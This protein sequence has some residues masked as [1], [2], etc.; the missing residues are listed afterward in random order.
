MEEKMLKDYTVKDVYNLLNEM[1]KDIKLFI[2]DL[3]KKKKTFKVCCGIENVYNPRNNTMEPYF[4]CYK[5]KIKKA[6]SNKTGKQEII[7]LLKYV[8]GY[9]LFDSDNQTKNKEEENSF[10]KDDLDEILK[11][12]AGIKGEVIINFPKN[13]EE[14]TNLLDLMIDKIE[15][16]KTSS[17]DRN[18]YLKS[19]INI[20][21]FV[22]DNYKILMYSLY[23]EEKLLKDIDDICKKYKEKK[24]I[25]I[26]NIDEFKRLLSIGTECES[27]NE[28]NDG[29]NEQTDF[30]D[31]V[32]KFIETYNG[33]IN[34]VNN[35]KNREIEV[36]R[37]FKKL[38]SKNL[39]DLKY[40]DFPDL[41]MDKE[42][43]VGLKSKID[44]YVCSKKNDKKDLTHLVP[45]LDMYYYSDCSSTSDKKQK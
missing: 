32:I 5:D 21:N 16:K 7:L 22:A 38:K 25:E 13:W 20:E 27:I 35:L 8:F 4:Y 12:V 44:K 19:L 37:A 18:D 14:L 11:N 39:D 29:H 30:I 26:E 31:L 40:S 17:K 43:Y 34:R 15:D 2:S 1:R 23:A 24:L 6:L 36:N 45:L 10:T 3:E 42:L 28:T 33:E 41:P 9:K